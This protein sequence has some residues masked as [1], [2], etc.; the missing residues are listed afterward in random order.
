M[1]YRFIVAGPRNYTDKDFVFDELSVRFPV[2]IR[3]NLEIVEGGASGVDRLARE[4]AI[5]KGVKYKTFDANWEDMTEPCVR[6]FSKKN[7][8]YNALAGMKRNTRMAEYAT[9]LIA[10]WDYKSKGTGDMIKQAK[11]KRM[12]PIIIKIE[13]QS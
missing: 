12:K 6:R 11:E 9:H 7:G 1:K 2:S 8:Y 4:W 13:T 10:F 5:E 3:H